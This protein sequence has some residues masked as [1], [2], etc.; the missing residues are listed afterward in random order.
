LEAQRGAGTNKP[1]ES[2][3]EKYSLPLTGLKLGKK[4]QTELESAQ[5]RVAPLR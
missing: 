4:T 2:S 1:N 5:V 3:P